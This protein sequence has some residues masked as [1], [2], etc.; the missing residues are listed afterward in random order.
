MQELNQ[1]IKSYFPVPPADLEEIARQFKP[2]ELRKDAFFLKEEQYCD[3]MA[4]VRSGLLRVYRYAPDGKEVTQ[5]ISTQGYFITDLASFV[6]D[7]PGRWNI[8]AL[9]DCELFCI[10][11]KAYQ[12]LSATVPKWA[13]L[14]KLFIARCFIMLEERIFSHLHLSAEA[15]YQ[16]L[17]A[18]SPE[19]FNLVPLQYLASMMGMTPETLSRIRAKMIS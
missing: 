11:R 12:G 2:V 10:N 18:D 17:M 6:F 3:R 15:R 19:L 4:F 7:T 13:E 5:W 14:D 8:Q 1:Y 9:S 16:K